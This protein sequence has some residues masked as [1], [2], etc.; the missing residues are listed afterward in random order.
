MSVK[1]KVTVPRGSSRIDRLRQVCLQIRRR[2]IV[3]H[4][5]PLLAEDEGLHPRLAL[6]IVDPANIYRYVEVRGTVERIEPDVGMVF[7]NAMAR[8]YQGQETYTGGKPGDE[9]VVVVIR[10]VRV[11]GMG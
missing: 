7:I 5:S 8:K 4:A 6:S 9:Y 2:T 1:R 10:P 11:S 3:A